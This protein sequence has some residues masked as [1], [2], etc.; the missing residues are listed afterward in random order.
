MKTQFSTIVGLAAGLIVGMTAAVQAQFNY[1]IHLGKVTI[2][3]YTGP[4]GDV[5]IPDTIEGKPV[6]SIGDMAF[7]G[8]WDRPNTSLTSVTI[9]DS[10]TSIE[11]GAF[12]ECTG[13]TSITIPDSVIR[14]GNS[15]FSGCTGLTSITIPDSVTSIGWEPFLGCTSLRGVFFEGPRPSFETDVFREAPN[16]TAYYLPEQTGWGSS[17]FGRP[18]AVWKFQVLVGDDSFGVQEG[19][20]SFDIFWAR[21]K[22]VVVEACAD[23]ANPEWVQVGTC[24]LTENVA[25]FSDPEAASQPG[26]FYRLREQ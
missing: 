24:T 22:V 13:L 15:A 10:V 20:L 7:A 23:L 25:P 6:T 26:R 4:G 1:V 14:I 16:V 19:H 21:D 5:A 18:T 9:P 8:T 3:G 12:S 11:G 17:S 2:T